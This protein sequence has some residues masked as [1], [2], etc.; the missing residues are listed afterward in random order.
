MNKRKILFAVLA[1][2]LLIVLYFSLRKSETDTNQVVAKVKRGSF[3]SLIFSSGQLESEKSVT[4]D[5]PEKLK[6][7][8]LRIYELT[9]THM[10]D[11]G[12]VVDSGDYVATLDQKAVEVQ[13][14]LAKYAMDKTL[15][16]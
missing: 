13:I 10:V 8:N 2:V 5:I 12:T 9:I 11:E 3:S 14:N 1:A 16:E 15:R 6:D 7:R 4:I